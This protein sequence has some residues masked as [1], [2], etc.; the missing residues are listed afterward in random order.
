MLIRLIYVEAPRLPMLSKRKRRSMVE[1][2][3]EVDVAE[4]GVAEAD[5]A[6]VDV[7]QARD[8]C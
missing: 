1:D 4:E 3:A 6:E 8:L 2:A 7:A 5:E